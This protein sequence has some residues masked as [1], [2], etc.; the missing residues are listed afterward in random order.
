M[1]ITPAMLQQ[2][3]S[4]IGTLHPGDKITIN[5]KLVPHALENWRI[6]THSRTTAVQLADLYGGQ[7]LRWGKQWEVYTEVDELPVALPP[8]QLVITQNMERWS[9]GGCLMRCDGERA[10]FPAVG[11]CTCPTPENPDDEASWWEAAEKRK[12]LVGLKVPRG[13]KPYTRLALVLADIGGVGV[14]KLT[15]TSEQ[16][17]AEIGKQAVILEKHRAR[18]I[19]LPARVAI[20]ARTA[21]VRGQTRNFVVPVLRLD[22]TIR[23]IMSGATAFLEMA[24]QLPPPPGTLAITAGP[25]HVPDSVEYT[26]G[27]DL[28]VTAQ[29]LADRAALA[30]DQAQVQELIDIARRAHLENDLVWARSGDEPGAPFDEVPL[31]QVLVARFRLLAA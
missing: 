28:A 18:G 7:P 8:G 22:N 31:P 13:C 9:G 10:T 12:E 19:F 25:A 21:L 2:R 15:S 1:A 14:F 17:A 29:S 6:T 16:A 24:R 11:P 27:P 30:T 23:E 20:E 5:D 3:N 26:G 4:V